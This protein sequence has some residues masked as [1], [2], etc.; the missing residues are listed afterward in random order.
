[1]SGDRTPTAP[2][3]HRRIL[4]EG[5]RA[6]GYPGDPAGDTRRLR[7][8]GVI[9]AD[10]VAAYFYG[11]DS[12]EH[13]QLAHNL[14]TLLPRGISVGGNWFIEWQVPV[15]SS[16]TEYGATMI[17]TGAPSRHGCWLDIRS[18]PEA[19]RKN[20]ALAAT[21]DALGY[22]RRARW[23]LTVRC[24]E[25][26]GDGPIVAL[27]ET[28]HLPLDEEGRMFWHG[29]ADLLL[30]DQGPPDDILSSSR[31]TVA[32][33][34]NLLPLAALICALSRCANVALIEHGESQGNRWNTLSIAAGTNSTSGQIPAGRFGWSSAGDDR[35]PI[36]RI[37]LR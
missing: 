5:P 2:V 15:R 14:P 6:A 24:F 18:S 30:L 22:A 3:L 12:P 19:L 32:D 33:L 26:W 16:L 35:R 1:M 7:D 17:L 20:A 23:L 21:L 28:G 36:W 8:A 10:N 4:R 31:G 37:R 9:I 34:N 27:P 11:P 13:W 25:M 29:G